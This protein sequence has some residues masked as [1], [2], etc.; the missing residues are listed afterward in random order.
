MRSLADILNAQDE[1]IEL[2]KRSSVTNKKCIS[3]LFFLGE[4]NTYINVT[5]PT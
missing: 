3:K 2:S 4:Q 1:T 5:S